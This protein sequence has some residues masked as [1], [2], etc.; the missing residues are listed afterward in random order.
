M[1][2]QLIPT[3]NPADSFSSTRPCFMLQWAFTM[4]REMQTSLKSNFDA[5]AR[6]SV[7]VF[8]A[9]PAGEF[10]LFISRGTFFHR[11]R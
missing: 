10:S 1:F 9:K 3:I 2:F 6:Q 7:I 11:L 8:L 4:Q 5:M